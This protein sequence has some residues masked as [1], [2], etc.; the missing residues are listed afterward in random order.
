MPEMELEN[1]RTDLRTLVSE[2][3][4][5]SGLSVEYNSIF[6]GV[7]GFETDINSEVIQVAEK[8]CGREPGTVAFGTEGPYLNAMGLDT[9]ILGPGDIDQAHQANEYLSLDRIP[10][11]MDILINMV[12][13]F[14]IRSD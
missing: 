11:M 2:T 3:V 7:P 13:H 1:I 4:A 12:N 6:D 9:V 10:P 14:C 5:G 8:L